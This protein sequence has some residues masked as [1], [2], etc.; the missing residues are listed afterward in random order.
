M[1]VA[2]IGVA[3][4]INIRPNAIIRRNANSMARSTVHHHL[5]K[6]LSS[7]LEKFIILGPVQ[8]L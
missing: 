5:L 8:I 1:R 4:I 2:T 7:D 6:T 3:A